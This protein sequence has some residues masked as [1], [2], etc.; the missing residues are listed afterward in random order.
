MSIKSDS[1]P[2]KKNNTTSN[3]EKD[4]KNPTNLFISEDR[5]TGEISKQVLSRILKALG[6]F[7]PLFL[8]SLTA[9]ASNIFDY[10]TQYE[11]LDWTK[12]FTSPSGKQDSVREMWIAFAYLQLRNVLNGIRGVS[13]YILTV[14]AAR[15]IHARMSF[16]LLHAKI[17]EFLERVPTGRIIN[18][19]TKD[20]NNIDVTLNW[21]INNFILNIMIVLVDLMVLVYSANNIYLSIPCIL[22]LAISVRYQRIYMSLKR[23]IV[24]LQNITNSPVIGWSI[25][26]LKSSCEVRVLNKMDYVRKKLKYLIDENTKNSIVI[27]GLDA[28]FQIRLAFFNMILVQLPSYSYILWSIYQDSEDVNV[29][30]LIIFVL[31]SSRLTA[32]TSNLLLGLSNLETN[33]VSIERC[34]RF[35]NIENEEDYK[36]FEMEEKKYT[37]PKKG[38][39]KNILKRQKHQG[40][41]FPEGKVELVNLTAKYQTKKKPVLSNLNLEINPG[42]KIG[43]VGRTGAGKTSFIKLFWRCL[44]PK[45]GKLLIDGKN[46][47][48][49][50]LK[51]LRSDVTVITQETSLFAGTL[52]ENIDPNLEYLIDKKSNLFKYKEN[53]ILKIL[54]EFGFSKKKMEND[55]LDF[56]I[57]FEGNNLSQGEKQIV[58]FIRALVEKK[59][60]VILDEATANIDLKTEENIQRRVEED[61]DGCTMFV[62][63]HRI[64]TVLGCDK[65][66]VLDEGKVVEFGGVEELIQEEGSKFSEI[67]RKLVEGKEGSN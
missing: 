32:D 12:S 30:N 48:E 42:E 39:I 24:R 19:F 58:C 44:D 61:F 29:Q 38:V 56:K 62:I 28:W 57:D 63:A 8:I 40:D 14:K 23:E 25:A 11:I 13:C 22:F 10:A 36:N 53:E 43:I 55:G 16:R 1:D 50:D 3:S 67:Y 4:P 33:L 60:V 46:I 45:S 35:E 49:L 2:G 21:N 5:E 31:S 20:I 66:L 6:G 17:G 65:I 54:R 52:R 34:Q 18:R 15:K 9:L 7:F 64:Q 37:F 51:A 59:K 47:S 27:Y 26:V 41:I